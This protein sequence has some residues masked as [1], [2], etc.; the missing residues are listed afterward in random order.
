[1][2]RVKK[3]LGIVMA[4]T[5]MLVMIPVTASA[6]VEDF[7]PTEIGMLKSFFAQSSVNG[8]TNGEVLGIDPASDPYSWYGIVWDDTSPVRAKMI[9]WVDCGLS[10]SLDVSGF[11][12]LSHLNC[13]NNQIASLIASG[14]E[15]LQHISCSD[16]GMTTLIVNNLSELYSLYCNNNKLTSLNFDDFPFLGDLNCDNNLITSIDFSKAE[17]NLYSVRCD[18]NPMT[19]IYYRGI[20]LR[21]IGNG[22]VGFSYYNMEGSCSFQAFTRDSD[23]KS[24]FQ[25]W[26]NGETKVS[27]LP[28][29][30]IGDSEFTYLDAVYGGAPVITPTPE[31]PTEPTITPIPTPTPEPVYIYAVKF[32]LDGG[33]RTGGGNETQYILKGKEAVAPTVERSGYKFLGWDKIFNEITEDITVNALWEEI[34]NKV[35]FDINS[36]IRTGGGEIYQYVNDGKAAT[37]PTVNRY[38]Y[39]LKG[40]DKEFSNVTED[41]TVTAIWKP[42]PDY[43]VTYDENGGEG[44]VPVDTNRYLEGEEALLADGSGL[45]YEG[46]QF[47]GWSEYM[48]SEVIQS[49]YIVVKEDTVLFA[50]WKAGDETTEVPTDVPVE[51]EDNAGGEIPKTGVPFDAFAGIAAML[52]GVGTTGLEIIHKRRKINS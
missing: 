37:A 29:Y 38:G 21:A 45:T 36:G 13:S 19:Q 15:R 42:A 44:T 32:N 52:F 51:P 17:E 50:V 26:M 4:I 43:E 48:D 7:E 11:L 41:M 10:G 9:N 24:I 27:E 34:P 3:F 23:G 40:W 20:T 49:D 16:N 30:T 12:R 5:M 25:G 39:I 47:M 18:G 22:Y 28:Y 46:Y 33:T 31:D 1:M 8:K 2:K 35:F 6:A 14:C